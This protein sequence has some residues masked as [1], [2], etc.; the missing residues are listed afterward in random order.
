MDSTMAT[1]KLYYIMDYSSNYYRVD[2]NEQLVVADMTEATVFSFTE[3]NKRIGSGAK[4]RFYFMTPVSEEDGE[5]IE[6]PQEENEEKYNLTA[7]FVSAVK[8]L[9]EGEMTEE[10]KKSISE[11][12]LSKV[13]WQEYLTHFT[14]IA[15]GLKE[16][17]ESLVKAQSDVD[18][19]ICDVLHYIELCNTG[20]EEATELVELLRVCRENRRD[21]KDEILKVDMFQKNLGTSANVAKAKEAIKA[22]KG[23][24]TRKY[25]PRKFTELFEGSSIK[26]RSNVPRNIEKTVCE[27]ND[28]MEPIIM[29]EEEIMN[30]ERRETVFDGKKNDWMAFAM[31]QAEFYRNAGQYITNL[32]MDIEDIDN[33]IADLMDEV[34]TANC[35]VAQGYKM[36]KRLKELRLERKEKEKELECL[37]I[38][39]E[40]FDLGAMAD[41]CASNAETISQYLYG[42]MEEGERNV[43]ALES[44]AA[45][46]PGEAVIVTDIAV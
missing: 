8:E 43:E 28:S 24:A 4:S 36:F 41:E 15:S 11:Y 1:D 40:H 35:N 32:R 27:S 16:Y 42:D 37:Y 3:A 23:L 14:F 29:E 17:K 25:T 6:L 38:L 34:E 46:E 20:D 19:K 2:S 44:E 5:E 18:Q 10:T 13:D 22:I 7:A 33:A 45:D 21:I 31:Q 39:T 30:L 9:T 12:D 26:I